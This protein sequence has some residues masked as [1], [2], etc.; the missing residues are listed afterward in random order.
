MNKQRSS[1]R[2][3]WVL[4]GDAPE[5]GVL[6]FLAVILFPRPSVGMDLEI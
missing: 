3:R 4:I 6:L 5:Q 2:M 1:N